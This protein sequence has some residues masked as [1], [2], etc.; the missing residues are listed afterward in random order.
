MVN[1]V[2]KE[3]LVQK[4]MLGMA[5]IYIL[6]FSFAMSSLGEKLPLA[7]ISAVGYMFVMYG[8]AW[9]VKADADRLWNSLPIPKWKIVA[10]KYLA[11]LIYVAAVAVLTW[12]TLPVL[13]RVGSATIPSVVRVDHAAAAAA[14][15]V[16]LASLYLPIYF[17]LGYMKARILNLLIFV[18]SFALASLLQSALGRQ[19]AWQVWVEGL[20]PAALGALAAGCVLAVASLSFLVSWRLYARRE[21]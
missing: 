17:A 5:L 13:S 16:G 20:G 4:R 12:V 6:L 1:L 19:P 9:D 3:L 7:I 2:L 21:F 10:A 15:V 11:V 18:G 14:V 8:G